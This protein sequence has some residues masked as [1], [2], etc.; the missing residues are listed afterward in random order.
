MYLFVK[1]EPPP[2]MLM[3]TYLH[4]YRRRR[5]S[6]NSGHWH[7]CFKV[8]PRTEMAA[9]AHHADH[10]LNHKVTCSL[11]SM[12]TLNFPSMYIYIM[13]IYIY[14]YL[15]TSLHLLIWNLKLAWLMLGAESEEQGIILMMLTLSRQETGNTFKQTNSK[16]QKIVW[17]LSVNMFFSPL[18]LYYIIFWRTNNWHDI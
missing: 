1:H 10:A 12:S 9:R 6:A 11:M 4:I 15:Y 8:G 17:C 3:S 14:K 5:N 7:L 13:S 18:F 16:I 2:P